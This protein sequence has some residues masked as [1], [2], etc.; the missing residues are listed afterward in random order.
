MT[1]ELKKWCIEQAAQAGAGD[2]VLQVAQEM[3]MFLQEGCTDNVQTL[4]R[5]HELTKS[6]K[7]ILRTLIE[8][9]RNGEVANGSSIARK[10]GY[11]QSHTSAIL[12]KLV[13]LE[14]VHKEG[15]TFTPMVDEDR[16]VVVNL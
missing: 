8:M 10:L 7:M 15:Y 9:Y 6:Q 2:K 11:T 1:T 13:D 16:Q 3:Y 4:K 5:P 14:Y 12:R